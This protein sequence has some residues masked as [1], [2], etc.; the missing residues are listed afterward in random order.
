MKMEPQ[1]LE[2]GLITVA[3]NIKAIGGE[4]ANADADHLDAKELLDVYEEELKNFFNDGTKI[5][6]AELTRLA[7]TSDKY[8]ERL[9]ELQ[10]K[11]RTAMGLKARLAGE[12][13][14]HESLRSISSLEKVKANLI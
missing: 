8:K 5:T 1:I 3:K 9:Q 10:Q 11:R 14:M 12:R 2:D 13:A 7:K 4:H 6:Q